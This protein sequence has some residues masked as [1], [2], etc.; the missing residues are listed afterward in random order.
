[1]SS[2]SNLVAKMWVL[3]HCLFLLLWKPQN[4]SWRFQSQLTG[5]NLD[6][7]WPCGAKILKKN[8]GSLDSAIKMTFNHLHLPP[9]PPTPAPSAGQA[10]WLLKG[11]HRSMG[12]GAVSLSLLKTM[13]YSGIFQLKIEDLMVNLVVWDPVVSNF[14]SGT[15]PLRNN[16]LKVPG[17][18]RNP[19][20]QQPK[21]PINH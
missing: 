1:M 17:N 10:S 16:P 8:W 6:T 11:F 21:A 14:E 7:L 13:T 2:L 5:K 9:S 18:I 19:N 4:Q 15:V 12:G 20:H 3:L